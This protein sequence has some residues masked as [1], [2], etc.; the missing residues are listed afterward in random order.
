MAED[1][2]IF[3]AAVQLAACA[4]A[5]AEPSQVL[6]SN[7]GVNSPPPGGSLFWDEGTVIVCWFEN[8]LRL[9]EAREG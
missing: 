3:G 4:Y 6:A 9:N 1:E 7:V 8:P 5:R 2:D